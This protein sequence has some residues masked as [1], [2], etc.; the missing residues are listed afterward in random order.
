MLIAFT[1]IF[2]LVVNLL[3]MYLTEVIVKSTYNNKKPLHGTYC[4]CQISI[5]VLSYTQAV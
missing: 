4:I 3:S 1:K 5:F 2:I